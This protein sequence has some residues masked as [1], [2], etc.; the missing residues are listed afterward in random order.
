MPAE[1]VDDVYDITCRRHSGRR[2]RVYLDVRDVPTLFDAGFADT[3]SAVEDGL[4]AL[5]VAPERL[6]LTHADQDHAGGVDALVERYGLETWAPA[7]SDLNA[8]SR[9]GRRFGH[10]ARVG[11]FEAVHVPGHT[12]DCYCFVDEDAGVAITGDALFGADYR[13]LPAGYL[14]VPPAVYSDDLHAAERN[15]DRLV[16]YEFDA[17]LVYHGTAVTEGARDV[18]DRYVNFPGRP[19]QPIK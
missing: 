12:P 14:V 1:V 17:A 18:L 19:D 10:G 3:V 5:G 6:V 9:P 15:L 4:D 8:A 2:F 11:R 16:D 7:E 13:G